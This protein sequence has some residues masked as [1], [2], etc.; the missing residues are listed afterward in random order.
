M[1]RG[2]HLRSVKTVRFGRCAV[3]IKRDADW[4]ELVVVA[5]SPVRRM[6]GTYHTGDMSDA[7]ATAADMI[8]R[9]RRSG[10]CR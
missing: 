7:R 6:S 10:G 1:A 8:R 2:D 9:M 3:S 5:K 4:D